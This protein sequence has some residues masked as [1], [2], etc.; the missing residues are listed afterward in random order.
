MYNLNSID[1]DSENLRSNTVL[2]VLSLNL[3]SRETLSRIYMNV[4]CPIQ[5]VD[6]CMF[7]HCHLCVCLSVYMYMPPHT[8]T[9]THTHRSQAAVF[10]NAMCT[11]PK[12]FCFDTVRYWTFLGDIIIHKYINI[13][14][15]IIIIII[16]IITILSSIVIF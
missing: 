3:K 7:V 5:S 15:T 12:S 14:I 8:H 11:R 10:S 13:I 1:N 2:L 4:R 16:T 9:H 6:H